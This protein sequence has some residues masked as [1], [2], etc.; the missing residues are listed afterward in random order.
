MGLLRVL[1]PHKVS[2][3]TSAAMKKPQDRPLDYASAHVF[4]GRHKDLIDKSQT[5][6]CFFCFSIFPATDI[7]DWTD[8]GRTAMCP[9]CWIDT[10]LPDAVVPVSDEFLRGMY[11]FWFHRME[12]AK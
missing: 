12:I 6:G 1:I 9:V 10:V 3:M 5:C 4:S 7:K 2:T 11:Q 8:F